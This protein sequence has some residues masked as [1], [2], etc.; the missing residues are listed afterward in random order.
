MV[1]AA[2]SPFAFAHRAQQA[3]LVKRLQHAVYPNGVRSSIA[4]RRALVHAIEVSAVATGSASA[5]FQRQPY[6]RDRV[7]AFVAGQR[8]A[9]G[10]V[11]YLLGSGGIAAINR[12]RQRTNRPAKAAAVAQ[13]HGVLCQWRCVAGA[14]QIVRRDSFAGGGQRVGG[15][16]GAVAARLRVTAQVAQHRAGF[17]RGQLVFVAQQHH[18]RRRRQGGQQRGH[19]F[20]MHHRGFIDDE[21][22]NVQRLAGVVAE[23]ARVRPRAQQRVQRAR[24]AHALGQRVQVERA[25]DA[26]AQLAQRGVDGLLQP[27]CGF[28]GGRGQCNAQALG[29]GIH[30]EQQR[31]Q[32]RGG[33][34]FAGAGAAGNH[35]KTPAQRQCAGEFLP[36]GRG[37]GC[38][39]RVGCKQTV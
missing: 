32:A 14:L 27:R 35:R 25:A 22:I 38:R 6:G 4:R 3:K 11:Q 5:A 31:Q 23:L 24:R 34:G 16:A 18:A 33:V 20:Q 37:V 21:H 10:V 17:N 15:G 8:T 7:H 2:R 9:F 1:Q 19:H 29:L 28:A 30:G 39:W 12:Q 13:H 26:L 36:V